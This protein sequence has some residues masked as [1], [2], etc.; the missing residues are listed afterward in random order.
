VSDNKT[1]HISNIFKATRKFN[2]LQQSDF[3]AILEITQGTVSKIES[4]LMLPELTL[5]FKF[6]K[7]FQISD[8]YCFTHGGVEFHDKAI[9]TILNNGSS[10]APISKIDIKKKLLT[11]RIIRPIFD[12]LFKKHLKSFEDFLKEQK[13]S[14]EIFYIFNHPLSQKFVESIFSFLQSQGINSKNLA[15]LDFNVNN[16]YGS[17]P[18]DP[19]N[20]HQLEYFFKAINSDENFIVNYK[21]VTRNNYYTATLNLKDKALVNELDPESLQHTY[22]MLYPYYFL[23][24]SKN[25]LSTAPVIEMIKKNSSWKISYAS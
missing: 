25:C 5:W 11:V 17:Q 3:A 10:L 16:T 2:R 14:I 24:S 18:L 15:L 1:V 7:Y 13:V 19:S 21:L 6:L 22:Y 20:E 23:K 4:G 8:P 12:Y 9:Q